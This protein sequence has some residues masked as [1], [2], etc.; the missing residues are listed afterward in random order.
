MRRTRIDDAGREFFQRGNSPHFS[1]GRS[2]VAPSH[3]LVHFSCTASTIYLTLDRDS[4]F[5]RTIIEH[6]SF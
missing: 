3:H 2:T 1:R 6:Q 5:G 4:D